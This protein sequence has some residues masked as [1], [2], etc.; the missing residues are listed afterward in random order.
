[1]KYIIALVILL[2][3][4]IIFA[5]EETPTEAPSKTPTVIPTQIDET[6]EEQSTENENISTLEN[7]FT[8]EDLQL[9]VGNVQ[10]PNGIAWHEG[11]LYTVCNGD[12]TL[13]RINDTTGDTITFVFG[14]KNGSDLIAES[15]ENGFDL[16]IPDGDSDTL[17]KVDHNRSAPLVINSDLISPWGIIRADDNSFLITSSRQN[18]ILNVSESGVVEEVFTGLRSPTGIARDNDFIYF[19]NGGSARRGLEWFEAV[20][21]GTYTEPQPLV[22]GLQNI[23]NVIIGNDGYLYFGYALGTRGV[24]GRVLPSN[25]RE[26]GCTNEDVEIVIFSDLPAPIAGLTIS[27]DM[28]IFLHSRYRPEI[29]WV[30]IPA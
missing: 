26:N 30:Q 29:Y 22:S 18:S 16:W 3:A 20:D 14:V 9:I 12:W 23:T 7:P 10:R 27:D 11:E 13:Y 28:R 21:D 24:V 8:Q 19:A 15:T 4:N 1:M 5:Q 25:C 17:W 2:S 6:N